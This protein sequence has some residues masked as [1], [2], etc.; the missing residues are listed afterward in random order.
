MLGEVAAREAGTHILHALKH[1]DL[2]HR[3]L[4]GG[5][6]GGWVG[7][8]LCCAVLRSRIVNS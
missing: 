8:V 7:A 3:Q 2:R 5:W 1:S 4:A 6:V